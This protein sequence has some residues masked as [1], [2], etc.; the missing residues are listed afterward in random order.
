MLLE[1]MGLLGGAIVIFILAE[2]ALKRTI[3]LAEHW[4]WSGTFIGMTVLS[5]GTS[6]PEIMSHIV[7]S[8]QIV[9]DYSLLNTLSS[10][11][12]GA[13]IGSDIFQQNFIL[14]LVAIIGVI[15]VHKKELLSTMGELIFAA[16]LLW[17][18][19][20]G[21]F[22]SRFEGALLVLAYIGYLIYLRMGQKK[23]KL[24]P[25]NHLKKH[26]ILFYS[27][28]IFISFLIMAV[29]TDFV[30]EMS[31]ELVNVIP[32]SA[33]FFGIIILG[34]AS[35]LPELSTALL[36][37]FKKRSGISAGVLIGSNITNPLLA[38]GLGAMIS[39]YSIPN[40][41][42]TY[43]LPIKIVTAGLIYYFLWRKEVLDKKRAVLLILLFIAYLIV[44]G[45]FFPADFVV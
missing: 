19:T 16:V 7:A 1:F 35:A 28:F 41:V 34:V 4:G 20:F 38:L 37:S 21:G 44:R 33:S 15:V 18:L 12:V 26:Q 27:I 13:N 2:L 17:I 39:S 5:I 40:V 22:I 42:I 24:N 36:A 6:I 3:D 32:I 11:V 45:I 14:P 30:L 8:V 10:L 25:K 9:N 31:K 29:V 23:Q 43:D